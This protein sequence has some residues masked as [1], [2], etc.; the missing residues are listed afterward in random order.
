LVLFHFLRSQ[1]RS[2][3]VSLGIFPKLQTEPYA[4]GS[5]QP[6]R[7]VYQENSWG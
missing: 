3:V 1:D 5:T 7:N 4:V 2:P 6:L